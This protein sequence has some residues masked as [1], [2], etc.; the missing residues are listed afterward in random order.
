[1]EKHG[2]VLR[3]GVYTAV[4]LAVLALSFLTP[5]LADDFSYCFSWADV[6]RVRSLA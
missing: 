4:F 1:M 3:R 2:A 5:M 6:S